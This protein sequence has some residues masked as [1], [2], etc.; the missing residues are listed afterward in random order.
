MIEKSKMSK[1]RKQGS[2][3]DDISS[4]AIEGAATETVQQIGSAAK[5]HVVAYSG[6]DNEKS[7]ENRYLKNLDQQSVLFP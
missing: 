4:V 1:K 7:G 3:F 6:I 5:E 2:K